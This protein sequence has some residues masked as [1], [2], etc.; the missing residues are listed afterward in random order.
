M[1][2]IGSAQ[3]DITPEL[4]VVMGGSFLKFECRDVHDPVMAGCVV[5]DDGRERAAMVSCDLGSVSR[6][7][8]QS[9]REQAAQATGM[10]GENIFVSATHNHSGPTV[11]ARR[12]NPFGDDE[13]RKTRPYPRVVTSWTSPTGIRRSRSQ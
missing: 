7:M 6:D 10:P 13:A 8:L 12:D 4:P 3:A 2:R 11:Q 9:I 5:A 1:L